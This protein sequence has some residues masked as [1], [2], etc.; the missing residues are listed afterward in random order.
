MSLERPAYQKSLLDFGVDF[1][2]EQHEYTLLSCGVGQESGCI[3][4]GL[5]IDDPKFTKYVK[6]KLIV[7]HADTL[8]ESEG[9]IKYREEL[10]KMC[11]EKGI[12]FI[13][14]RPDDKVHQELFYSKAWYGGLVGNMD[15]YGVCTSQTYGNRACTMEIKINPIYNWVEYMI[16]KTYKFTK[17]YNKRKTNIPRYIKKFGKKINVIIGFNFNEQNRIKQSKKVPKWML[18]SVRFIY[19]LIEEKMSRIDTHDYF[20]SIGR[21]IPEPSHCMFCHF[22]TEKDLLLMYNTKPD[23]YYKF[24]GHESN[25]VN[26][27]NIKLPLRENAINLVRESLGEIFTDDRSHVVQRKINQLKNWD[28]T[29]RYVKIGKKAP[30]IIPPNNGVFQK[31]MLPEI[32]QEATIKFRNQ[33]ACEA[34]RSAPLVKGFE[35]CEEC[36]KKM[37]NQK[38]LRGH[39]VASV[40]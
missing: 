11:A 36:V 10:K 13:H 29:P 27:F 21:S 32:L 12:P 6:G 5:I 19:P 26:W 24:V 15:R 33:D 38:M 18:D 37:I 40:Y 8:N 25:K 17:T 35:F 14:L 39:N 7:I 9:T 20:R 34:C 30:N 1:N 22:V 23:Q 3:T 2:L 31:G 4:E 28:E 16:W